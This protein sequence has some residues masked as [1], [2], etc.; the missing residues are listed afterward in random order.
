MGLSKL[1]FSNRWRRS[2]L[3]LIKKK[4]ISQEEYDQALA[5]ILAKKD[6]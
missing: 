5:E 4:V 6:D 2:K 3:P 1:Q